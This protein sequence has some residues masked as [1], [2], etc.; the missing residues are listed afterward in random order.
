MPVGSSQTTIDEARSAGDIAIISALAFEL[1]PL[2]S[3]ID[4]LPQ[5]RIRVYQCGPGQER[6]YD[7]ARTAVAAGASALVSWGVAGGLYRELPSGAIVLPRQVRSIA[8]AEFD[9]DA[10]WHRELLRSL[11]SVFPV[12]TGE[13]C[14]S[15]GVLKTTAAKAAIAD[16]TGAVAVDMESAAIAK[17]A[18]D[19]RRPF[20][21]IRVVLDT[22]NDHLP[23]G[24]EAWID[25]AGNQRASAVWTTLS[26]PGDWMSLLKLSLRYRAARKTLAGA[27][28]M[29]VPRGLHLPN[30][31][32][33]AA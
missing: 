27:S 5:S 9:T 30:S 28:A 2:D 18:A 15:L 25:E 1:A 7:A 21:A 32:A 16:A 22:S 19:A 31:T 8:G 11:Q 24:I 33:A 14:E 13:L 12:D 6:A 4:A 20:V 3:Q 29:L 26:R 23:N 10:R 17:A